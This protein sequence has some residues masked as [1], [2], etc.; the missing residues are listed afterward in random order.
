VLSGI[1]PL[2]VSSSHLDEWRKAQGARPTG[3]HY[4]TRK[5]L[6]EIVSLF[7]RVKIVFLVP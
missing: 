5:N 7:F 3:I 6:M 1:L 2:F 4:K